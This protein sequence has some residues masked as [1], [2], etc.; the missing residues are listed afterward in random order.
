M[1][2]KFHLLL[3]FVLLGFV[4]NAQ[5]Q[6]KQMAN[7][8]VRNMLVYQMMN[9]FSTV[10]PAF[11]FVPGWFV[12]SSFQVTHV[13]VF[14]DEAYYSTAEVNGTKDA[15]HKEL[16]EAINIDFFPEIPDDKQME[17]R[18]TDQN[19]LLYILRFQRDADT[20]VVLQI[21]GKNQDEKSFSIAGGELFRIVKKDKHGVSYRK[22]EFLGDTMHMIRDYDSKKEMFNHTEIRFSDGR[23]DTKTSFRQRSLG[24]R[25]L[26]S[27]EKYHYLNKQL[28]SVEKHN[29][30][31]SLLESTTYVHNLDNKLVSISKN[32]LK[33]NSVISYSY[34]DEGFIKKKTFHTG[35]KDY[36]LKYYRDNGRVSGFL[37]EGLNNS[38]D[39]ELIFAINLENQLSR[40]QH[41]KRYNSIPPMV[42]TEEMLF[43]YH[44]N[45][46]IKSIRI[47]DVQGRLTK[48]INF[49]YAYFN[50]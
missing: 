14:V 21:S 19:R 36:S 10:V 39:N 1:K 32:S 23:L 40:L 6:D 7:S 5:N 15:L 16:Y 43:D 34:D 2:T 3:S 13:P 12:F 8:I 42:K 20:L 28:S 41:K 25:R 37:I 38:Y 49:E 47:F 9:D 46:N 18:V 35:N 24:K 33:V 30:N 44:S 22:S 26:I 50:L 29:R 17:I 45:G 48:D 4:A 31:G 11:F 27:T